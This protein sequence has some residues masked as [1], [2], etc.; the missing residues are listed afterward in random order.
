MIEPGL[1]TSELFFTVEQYWYMCLI[2]PT[3]FA[4]LA[5]FT[6][7]L[8]K[9]EKKY[10]NIKAYSASILMGSL[11]YLAVI[12]FIGTQVESVSGLSGLISTA[13]LA[14]YAG[15][16]LLPK[17]AARFEKRFEESE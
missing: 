4:A 1:I 2:I 5:G 3:L 12:G 7:H 13:I 11:T 10:R 17:L 8:I 9:S 16:S 14:G 6:A 15:R